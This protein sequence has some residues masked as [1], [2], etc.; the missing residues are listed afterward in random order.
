LWRYANNYDLRL[1]ID[2]V[3]MWLYIGPARKLKDPN[4]PFHHVNMTMLPGGFV[5]SLVNGWTGLTKL[6]F[7]I[8]TRGA[9][10]I[11]F[12]YLDVSGNMLGESDHPFTV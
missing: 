11:H 1:E 12:D 5:P 9:K 4:S 3:G 8:Q 10:S 2:R 6:K 7:K